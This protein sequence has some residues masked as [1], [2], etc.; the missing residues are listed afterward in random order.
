MMA[1][2]A[3]GYPYALIPRPN[4]VGGE[5]RNRIRYAGKQKGGASDGEETEV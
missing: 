3:C 1:E 5:I 2:S 4:T